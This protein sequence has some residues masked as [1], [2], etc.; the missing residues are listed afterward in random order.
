MN[1]KVLI[2]GIGGFVGKYL[3]NELTS[4][5]Y[6]VYGCDCAL[7][8][9]LNEELYSVD[10]TDYKSV[11][12][13][14]AEIKPSYIFNLAAISSVGLS[15]E[16]PQDTIKVNVCGTVNILE[17]VRC[18]NLDA[19]L[20]LVGSSEEYAP[21]NNPVAEDAKLDAV[22]PYGISRI[23]VEQFAN[24][25]RSRYGLKI[26]CIRAFNHTGIGQ[27]PV[28]VLPSFI[29][30]A[31][32]ISLSQAP[33]IIKVGNI[34]VY[35]DFSDVRDIVRAYR[36]IAEHNGNIDVINV[37]SGTAHKIEDLLNFIISLSNQKIEV[38]LDKD[39]FR[40]ADLPYCC[41]NNSLLK[42]TTGWQPQ[43]D[44]FDTLREMFDLRIK[45]PA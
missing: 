18:L 16:K 2:I 32:R 11:F 27:T 44:I 40:P 22:N 19:K 25:Y 30:Q 31:A 1:N 17:S 24:I 29:E 42:N 43:Y 34:S 7:K 8:Q 20:L 45:S 14:I 35:R 37:G 23:T 4:H 21:S 10:I 36:L 6:K 5:G 9:S 39:K 26:T 41:C 3:K 28:F 33:G 12:N 15:W 13:L 38:V